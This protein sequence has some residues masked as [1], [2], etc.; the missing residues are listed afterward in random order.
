[1]QDFGITPQVIT[2]DTEAIGWVRNRLIETLKDAPGGIVALTTHA[3]YLDLPIL[4]SEAKWRVI[5]DEVPKLD[6]PFEFSLPRNFPVLA[7]HLD[8]EQISAT[9]GLVTPKDP[10]HLMNMLRAERDDCDRVFRDFLF[11]VR[12]KDRT[13]YVDWESW[14]QADGGVQTKKG[15]G[16]RFQAHLNARPFVGNI[17]MGAN[18]ESS[19]LYHRL[20]EECEFRPFEPICSG[21]RP[22][23]TGST[24]RLEIYY[25][26]EHFRASKYRFYER[27][28]QEDP[29]NIEKMD[30]HALALFG[31][32]D[33]LNLTNKTRK[34]QLLGSRANFHSLPVIAH[35]LNGYQDYKNLYA[36]LALN[37]KTWEMDMLAEA[38]LSREIIDC[39]TL[40]ET[41]YQGLLRTNLRDPNGT[42]L[43]RALVPDKA[44][45]LRLAE[46]IPTRKLEHLPVCE[47]EV[48]A[49]YTPTQKKRRQRTFALMRSGSQAR[50]SAPPSTIC[51]PTSI[52]ILLG[53]GGQIG[54][55]APETTMEERLFEASYYQDKFSAPFSIPETLPQLIQRFR[56][57]SRTD[58]ATKEEMFCV[59]SA[60]FERF[61][62]PGRLRTTKMFVRA[63]FLCL[64]FDNGNLSPEDFIRHFGKTAP[65]EQ[66]LS[67]VI[68]NTFSRCPEAPN[69]FRV[70]VFYASPVTAP[71]QHKAALNE[72]LKRLANVGF[73]DPEAM[74]LDDNCKSAVQGYYLPCT[75]RRYPTWHFF[76]AVN[77]DKRSFA[78]YAL[79]PPIC[80]PSRITPKPKHQGQQREPFTVLPPNH[81]L[82]K[83][84]Q[85]DL[86]A[87]KAMTSGRNR[88]LYLFALKL[89]ALGCSDEAIEGWLRTVSN[90]PG[91]QGKIPSILESLRKRRNELFSALDENK[92]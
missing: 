78:K 58:V 77:T 51:L 60:I 47:E 69:R 31:D 76:E 14:Q 62:D 21:L 64:D 10:H 36:P 55:S 52:D 54:D 90:E 19:L 29:S 83:D 59:T 18:I 50:P 26:F 56:T 7:E 30:E 17:L 34:S 9:L 32:E 86:D 65:K 79:R 38:G 35:G 45:A 44:S 71:A 1:L 23:L 3:S 40:H 22:G 6:Q 85:E 37:R 91:I 61:L 80:M 13:T 67:F 68:C 75:N 12:S 48:L 11:A 74:A 46:L 92:S 43:V 2:S 63:H 49:P 73:G 53:D 15:V 81:P 88:P 28:E 5:I 39:A 72:I 33:T 4:P 25:C 42:E 82:P 16:V 87:L 89:E 57:Y 24:P 41:L 27:K 66:R 20:K 84:A 8:V 70:F